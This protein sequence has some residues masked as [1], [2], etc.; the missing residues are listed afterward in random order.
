MEFKNIRK[1]EKVL[2]TKLLL[3]KKVTVLP[4]SQ[5]PRIFPAI[6]NVL[7]G[8]VKVTNL[9]TRFA[10]SNE[11]VYAKLKRKLE[12]HGHVLLETVRSVF[13]DKLLR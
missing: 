12:F 11:L 13:S 6:C 2:I 7:V 8:T 1:L 4:S 9:L 10:D 3:F 5:I